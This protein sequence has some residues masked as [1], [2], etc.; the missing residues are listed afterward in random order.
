MNT[1]RAIP[2]VTSY[3]SD[4]A[5]SFA[6]DVIDASKVAERLEAHL[7]RRTGRRRTL[8]A[9]ALLVALL[10][11]ALD[12]RPLHLKAATK[13]LYCALD[14]HWRATLG[15]VGD[16][17]THKS[18]LARYRCVRYLFHLVT[19]VMDPSVR[20]EEPRRRPSSRPRF[21]QRAERVRGRGGRRSTRIGAR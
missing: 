1:G 10:L 20:S 11:L 16:A 13:L 5:V 4:E 9:R 6:I 18:L 7:V 12:D 3:L 21:G 19:S 15:V 8:S 14:V 17:S 2:T